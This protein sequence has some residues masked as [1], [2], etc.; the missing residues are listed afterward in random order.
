MSCSS[1]SLS[2]IEYKMRKFDQ[3]FQKAYKEILYFLLKSTSSLIILY[4]L[5]SNCHLASIT[6]K[7]ISGM[8]TFL[9]ESP[10]VKLN[11]DVSLVGPFSNVE[12]DSG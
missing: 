1:L 9:S 11:S 3:L 6:E 12:L 7:R 5:M 8:E 10:L 2:S 4:T